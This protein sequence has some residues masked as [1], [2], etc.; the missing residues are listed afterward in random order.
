MGA[1]DCDFG[2]EV[3]G[4]C[5]MRPRIARTTPKSGDICPA[6]EQQ[7]TIGSECVDEAGLV[8]DW[9]YFSRYHKTCYDLCESFSERVCGGGWR[10]PFDF[11]DAS[12]HAVANW[13]DPFWRQWLET[14]E[15]IWPRLEALD[16]QLKKERD[17]S[18]IAAIR[19]ELFKETL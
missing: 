17:A 16:I 4:F 15:T 2:Y 9:G 18:K 6:C 13:D 3:I 11:D 12:R 19:F 10:N 14:Y 8:E 5:V 1:C 7:V